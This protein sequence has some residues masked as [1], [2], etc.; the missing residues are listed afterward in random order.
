M[1]TVQQRQAVHPVLHSFTAEL[2]CFLFV[3]YT[4]RQR[5]L[6]GER[7]PPKGSFF[8]TVQPF[9][10]P[11]RFQS[12]LRFLFYFLF[13][14]PLRTAL[15]SPKRSFYFVSFAV[16]SM[17]ANKATQ[18]LPYDNLGLCG[19]NRDEQS[20]KLL[21]AIIFVLPCQREQ[22]GFNIQ[23]CYRLSDIY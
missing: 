2:M 20:M 14:F 4:E 23:I 22:I 7:I 5:S 17:R 6:A 12:R 1:S 21:L 10:R 18:F 8:K 11:C 16:V 13:R 15:R 9:R 19:I 3:F